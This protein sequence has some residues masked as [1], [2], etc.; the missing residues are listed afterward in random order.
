VFV[1]SLRPQLL[2]RPGRL[3][4]ALESHPTED[5]R[6]LREL[7]L[8]VFDD[9]HEIAP[10]IAEVEPGSGKDVDPRLY[11]GSARG[12]PIVDD[13]AQVA[14]LVG[15][16][17]AALGERDELVADVDEGRPRPRSSSSNSCP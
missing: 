17:G 3:A 15:R 5:R 2:E 7:D 9:L 16:L 14:A 1:E 13:Q 11:Q 12:C 4:Q 8:G 10:R 6:C